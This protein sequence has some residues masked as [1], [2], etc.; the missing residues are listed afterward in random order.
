MTHRR[1]ASWLCSWRALPLHALAFALASCSTQPMPTDRPI[2]KL[3]DN[4]LLQLAS[5]KPDFA[6][7][8]V[9]LLKIKSASNRYLPTDV[10]GLVLLTQ[11]RALNKPLC[12]ALASNLMQMDLN[13]RRA[14]VAQNSDTRLRDVLWMDKRPND[15]LSSI[16][17]IEILTRSNCPEMLENYDFLASRQ[18][19]NI[20]GVKIS[21]GGP[22]LVAAEPARSCFIVSNLA[23]HKEDEIASV[24]EDWRTVLLKD[25]SLWRRNEMSLWAYLV[26][27]WTNKAPRVRRVCLSS[28]LRL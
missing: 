22:W 14:F 10:Y 26:G 11:D 12:E 13:K 20:L 18:I 16:K 17:A 19:L 27:I 9:Q 3:D 23:Q 28:Q 2:A 15:A 24:V 21:E 5:D 7:R 1:Q 8:T 6:V 4:R 25:A